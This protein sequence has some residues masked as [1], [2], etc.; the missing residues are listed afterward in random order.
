M[1]S[2][3]RV[4]KTTQ[5]V[6]DRWRAE[7]QDEQDAGRKCDQRFVD[8]LDDID[9]LQAENAKNLEL[10]DYAIKLL[11][12]NQ[13]ALRE[14]HDRSAALQEENERMRV[15]LGGAVRKALVSLGDGLTVDVIDAA[16]SQP[17]PTKVKP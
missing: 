7:I 15:L 10:A 8:L 3:G 14:E 5:S 9:T 11:D 4:A 16:L 12:R 6:R 13:K 2:E 17:T 1:S